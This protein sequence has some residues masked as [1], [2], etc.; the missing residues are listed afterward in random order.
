MQNPVIEWNELML[1]AI[2]EVKPGPPM[3][4]RSI[5]VIHTSIY[6][7][8]AAYDVT[9]RM[10]RADFAITVPNTPANLNTSIHYAAYVAC[11]DQFP[12][13]KAIFD[14][15][16]TALGLVI[17]PMPGAATNNAPGVGIKAAKQVLTFRHADGSNQANGYADTTGYM[18]SNEVMYPLFP[19]PS[20][21]IT[22]PDRWQSLSYLTSESKPASPQFIAPHWGNV[23]PF[24]LATGSEFRP[25]A[26]QALTSQGFLDQAKHVMQVQENLTIEQKVQAEY[27]ADGPRSELPPGHWTMFASFVA[28]R[29]HLSLENTIKL[30]FALSNAIF[31]ASI[32][33]WEAKR[34]YDYCRPITA[35]RHLFHGKKIKGWGGPGKGII[36]MYGENWRTFQ[37]Y[38]FPT[39]PFAEF[40]SGHSAFS[41]AAAT[42]LKEF[43]GSDRF[44]YYYM[45]TK[46]LSAEPTDTQ[47]I[48]VT[49]RWDTFTD[50]AKEAGESRLYGGIHFYEGNVAGLEMGKKVGVKAFNQAKGF[51]T[52]IIP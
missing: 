10:T 49:M 47:A 5:A 21:G 40:T 26:P 32:A 8:W 7:T 48:G 52:G 14:A 44:G 35:I 11:I 41:M 20:Y 45:Q 50:A 34:F 27:W 51:W 19:T 18:P 36:D 6:D 13:V 24:A 39:P 22:Y 33:T 3:A 12:T 23:V 31:D 15:K 9:A 2:R 17:S 30:F 29:D 16:M 46:T 37:V 28:E 25:N 1:S 38:T 43:T 4:A 42:V